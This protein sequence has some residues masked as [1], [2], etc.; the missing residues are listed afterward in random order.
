MKNN[1]KKRE[2]TIMIMHEWRRI[3]MSG[4]ASID[5]FHDTLELLNKR[6]KTPTLE[7][8]EE[9]VDDIFRFNEDLNSTYSL[10]IQHLTM[11]LDHKALPPEDTMEPG[12][13]KIF[14][15]AKYIYANVDD[16]S[17]D[18]KASAVLKAL[19]I[20][21]SDFEV[22]DYEYM[23]TFMAAVFAEKEEKLARF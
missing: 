6:F 12:I 23:I 4:D 7:D 15:Y 1:P 11:I 17:L 21:Y 5:C 16:I 13:R 9:M 14:F 18:G 8:L 2:L 20:F 19:D 22:G 3:R 10:Y